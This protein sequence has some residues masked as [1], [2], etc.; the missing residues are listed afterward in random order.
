MTRI[1]IDHPAMIAALDRL[2][3]LARSD[4]G[5]SA[6][7]A[8][9]LMA[10]WNG[11]DLDDFPLRICLASTAMWRATSPRSSDFWGSMMVPSTS[12]AWDIALRWSPLSSAGRRYRAPAPRPR[13]DGSR[14]YRETEPC[15]SLNSTHIHCVSRRSW[16]ARASRSLR[17]I[18]S[19][20][21]S[22]ASAQARYSSSLP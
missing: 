3:D 17:A 11:P 10:W 2:L 18:P 1:E 14:R 9:F 13:N 8:R 22:N 6:R 19:W 21:A 12:T 7:V 15:R 5:Q 16:S 20:T 4:T